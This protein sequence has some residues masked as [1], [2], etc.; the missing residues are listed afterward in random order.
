MIKPSSVSAFLLL[1]MFFL[2][3]SALAQTASITGTVTD[4]TGAVIPGA[5]VSAQNKTTNAIRATV[6]DGS[7]TY[8]ITNLAPGVYGVSIEKPGF[9]ATEYSRVE[10]TVDQVQSLDT[11]LVPSSV[12]E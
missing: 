6:T 2:P 12:A 5:K 9:K 11:T 1:L 3:A 10:L 4:S 8:R 7:G